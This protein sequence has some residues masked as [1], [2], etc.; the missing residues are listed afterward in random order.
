VRPKVLP[1]PFSRLLEARPGAALSELSDHVAVKA[2]GFLSP[3]ECRRYTRAVYEARPAWNEDFGGAQLSL[4]RAFYTHLEEGRSSEYFSRQA[5]SDALLERHLPGFAAR[6]VSAVALLGGNEAAPRKGWCGPGI[7]IFPA[8]A[9]VSEDGGSVHSDCEG[10][11]VAHVEARLPAIT[12]VAMLQPPVSG[13]G[14]RIWNAFH[15]QTSEIDP[16]E[17]EEESVTVPYSAGDLLLLDSYR[18]HQIR[19]FPGPLDRISATAH[20]A[21]EAGTWEVWF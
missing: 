21:L 5:E 8:G 16:E 1:L 19:P 12:V 2:Q 18:L 17:I 13:G 20:A 7:H 14:L 9:P 15:Y 6:L 10:L 3:E 11:S 4:G